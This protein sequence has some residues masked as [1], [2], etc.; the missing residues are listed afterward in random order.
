MNMFFII[1]TG[2]CGT[3]MLRNILGVWSDVVILPE[4]H[5]I[6][7]L[8]DKFC[9]D[10]VDVHDFLEVVDNIYSSKGDKWVKTILASSEIDYSTYKADFAN[11]VSRHSIQGTIKEYTES[12]FE[13]LYGKGFMFGDKTPHYG[14][15]LTIIRKLWP[16]AKIIHLIR[17]G[18][19]CAHSM[20]GHPGFV[21]YINGNVQPRDLDR[22][23]FRGEHLKFS[24]EIPSMRQAVLFWDHVMTCTLD[25]LQAIDTQGTLQVRYEDILFHPAQE[26]TRIAEFLGIDHDTSALNKAM[27]IPRPFPEKH[28]IRKVGAKEYAQYYSLVE[29]TMV[30]LGYPYQADVKRCF[31][32]KIHEMYR[33]RY[34]Y[35]SHLEKNAKKI[36]K[37]LIKK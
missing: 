34:F 4:T 13:F 26:L 18:I 20:R 14:T 21:K 6:I 16:E 33:G 11:Y 19:D 23:M 15:N 30:K 32:G 7:P 24:D 22:V 29:S 9:L 25:E 3:Q 17:D 5:F 37:R 28:Q 35:I 2:R 31:T 12:F 1:G 10:D 36:I 8:Y 27:T